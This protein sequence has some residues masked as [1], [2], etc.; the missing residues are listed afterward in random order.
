V[1]KEALN[2]EEYLRVT[3][4]EER[5]PY[6]PYPSQLGSH[7]Y[8][9]FYKRT[10]KILDIGCG[11]GE[12]LKT[13]SDLG[14]TPHGVDISP[15]ALEYGHG[16]DVKVLNLEKEDLSYEEEF[17]FVF[18]KSV[19]EHMRNPI[20]LVESAHKNLKEGGVAVIMTP[21]WIHNYKAAFYIDHT[22]V[23]PF[24]KPSLR[25]MMEMA[26]FKE[27]KVYYFYQIPYLWKFPY[28]KFFS[29]LVSF[30][31]IPYAPLNQ[32]PW[33]TSNKINKFVRFSK[34]VM[35]LAVAKK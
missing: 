24:T 11:R 17:D 29:K 3:Y 15:T 7:I 6:G 34:E 16:F 27:V 1:I 32:V 30:L 35:L 19:V 26:G 28:L 10:G 21:S 18:S 25:D 14:L 4:S 20:A 31:P 8:S 13:F 33:K 12:Y 23:T 9:N 5:A 2:N 22:H